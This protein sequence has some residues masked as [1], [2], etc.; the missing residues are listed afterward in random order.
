MKPGVG[1]AAGSDGAP[2]TG[3][4]VGTSVAVGG[5]SGVGVAVTTMII[6]V[7]VGPTVGNGAG[8]SV[9]TGDELRVALGVGAGVEVVT[10]VGGGEGLMAT[11]SAVSVGSA[12]SEGVTSAT[13]PAGPPIRSIVP[14][15]IIKPMQQTSTRAP[16]PIATPR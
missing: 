14:P 15:A 13:G 9:E 6:G 1:E 11:A 16:P 7:A 12:V 8:V 10:S 3:V 4:L 2:P 5:G